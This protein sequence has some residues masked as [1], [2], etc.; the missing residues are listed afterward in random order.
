M[1][2]LL[3]APSD[4]LFF[5]DGRPMAG[6]LAGHSAAWPLPSVTNAALHA[7][8]W[9]AGFAAQAHAHRPAR[10]GAFASNDRESHGERFGSL[11]T[12]GPFPVCT[13]GAAHTWFFPRPLDAIDEN[14]VPALALAP[15]QTTPG[16][17]SSI[18]SL[19]LS[20]A[21][22]STRPPSKNVPAAWWS[23]GAWNTYLG[24]TQRPDGRGA[25]LN[26]RVFF[27]GDSDFA[28]TEAQIGI[29]ID[30]ATGTTGHGDAA[31]KIYT[32]HYLRLR[33][34]WRLGLFAK[35]HDKAFQHEVHGN[36]LI[37]TLLAGGSEHIVVG[38]QQRVCS[39][40]FAPREEVASGG[41][42]PLP[43]GQRD[44]FA[45]AMIESAA[46]FLVKWVLL[47]P[48]VWPEIAAGT[49]AR[50]TSVRHHPGG[51][52]P[53]W[54]EPGTLRVLLRSVSGEV[55][56]ER[57]QL[58][59]NGRGYGSEEKAAAINAR[60]VAAVV[61][62]PIVVTGWS[63]GAPEAPQA[64]TASAPG[65][66]PTHLAVPAGAVYYFAADTADDAKA[67]ASSL[68]WHGDTAGTVIS[69][70]RSTLL[71]EKGFGLGVCGTWQFLGDRDVR[72]HSTS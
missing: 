31:G 44:G 64:G 16:A 6:S 1:H 55:R 63:L 66:K 17:V 37:A 12:A 57:R 22:A 38:G 46:R 32:A 60:L 11:V 41:R 67:L 72:G 61:P 70:R 43:F 7:A 2:P 13:A 19:G 40:S 49:S 18:D 34:G 5:R 50:G 58:N 62:K 51:W 24:T 28:D 47:S 56:H 8:L 42:L 27:K 35:A 33:D 48:A 45:T 39:A 10:S 20:F 65:A 36:D 69:R 53:N 21:A 71:G 54:I 68:N 4:V 25:P 26:A 59:Y 30:A 23:E 3:L 9:R 52:L 15:V 29:Q 14:A